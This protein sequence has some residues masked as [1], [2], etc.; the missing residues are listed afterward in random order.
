[1]SSSGSAGSTAMSEDESY[2]ASTHST[3]T[4]PM[5]VNDLDSTMNTQFQDTMGSQEFDHSFTSSI[6][7]QQSSSSMLSALS[8]THTS[9]TT[10]ASHATMSDRPMNVEDLQHG[11][12]RLYKKPAVRPVQSHYVGVKNS[13][14]RPNYSSVTQ[15]NSL[16]LNRPIYQIRRSN[17][18][19][20]SH[21]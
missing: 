10:H 8:A 21:V 14:S 18:Y 9:H 7:S 20:H 2:Y 4:R 1:M 3:R 15:Q 12:R 17:S 13:S 5:M 19:K 6:R 16:A 11:E